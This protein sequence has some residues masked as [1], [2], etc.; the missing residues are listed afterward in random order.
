MDNLHLVNNFVITLI[1]GAPASGKSTISSLISQNF[2]KN[3]IYIDID[4]IEKQLHEVFIQNG[5]MG[6]DS[7]I[8][9]S[10]LEKQDNILID[11]QDNI[12][13][14]LECHKKLKYSEEIHKFNPQI[15][16][17]SRNLSQKVVETLIK[18]TNQ[19]TSQF[20]IVEDV[21]NLRSMRKNYLHIAQK[22]QTGFCEILIKMPRE[23][24]ILNDSL[25]QD[26]KK[27]GENIILKSLE[28]FDYEATHKDHFL[29]FE[30][31]NNIKLEKSINNLAKQ[32]VEIGG[33]IAQQNKELSDEEYQQLLLE[34][35][36][37]IADQLNLKLNE[38][39]GHIIKNKNYD[40]KSN[41]GG[42]GLSI[43]KKLFFKMA[44]Y[45]FQ[46]AQNTLKS[47][48]LE[49]PEELSGIDELLKKYK[50]KFKTQKDSKEFQEVVQMIDQKLKEIDLCM[51]R[52]ENEQQFKIDSQAEK[53]KQI[54][55]QKQLFIQ[56]VVEKS[57]SAFEEFINKFYNN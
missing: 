7:T 53:D 30:N 56:G 44:K 31:S 6:E 41:G 26:F 17:I 36:E 14:Q 57:S 32:I 1:C 28:Q 18:K 48:I 8:N 55:M 10:N 20:I 54:G 12:L 21:F 27:V 46:Q 24:I 19:S 29:L 13:N 3:C 9:Q 37:N 47:N 11:I 40:I 43:L 39:V 45:Y 49:S 50:Q 16:K 25:R 33:K 23:E 42:E 52:I 5:I 4:Q 22:Y 15:W 51:I 34:H 35:K 2:I 38:K